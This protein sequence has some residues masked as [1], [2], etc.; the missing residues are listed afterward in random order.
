MK[1]QTMTLSNGFSS[2]GRLTG[3]RHILLLGNNSAS[4]LLHKSLYFLFF[5]LLIFFF[6]LLLKRL[7]GHPLTEKLQFIPHC[8]L[9]TSAEQVFKGPTLSEMVI[10]P[11]LQQ[12]L[13]RLPL[14]SFRASRG[15]QA[16]LMNC[17]A[18]SSHSFL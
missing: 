16:G 17:T 11:T 7:N 3:Y 15:P 5:M 14:G 12:T 6:K 1:Q 4:Y 18:A 13:P 8:S 10:S 9:N 2:L